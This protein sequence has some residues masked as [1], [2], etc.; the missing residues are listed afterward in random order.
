MHGNKYCV[1]IF[2]FFSDQ[3]NCD[4]ARDDSLC[5][6]LLSGYVDLDTRLDQDHEHDTL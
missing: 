4:D 6:C 3:D 1:F 5:I 2:I